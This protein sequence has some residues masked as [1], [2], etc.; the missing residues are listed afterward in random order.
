MREWFKKLQSKYHTFSNMV[1]LNIVL[2][3][4]AIDKL[5]Y[6]FSGY[7]EGH[8]NGSNRR[9]LISR[10]VFANSIVLM[11]AFVFTPKVGLE[12]VS[13][14][15]KLFSVLTVGLSLLYFVWVVVRVLLIR[16]K[17]FIVNPRRLFF[18]CLI[19]TLFTIVA[20]SFV[21]RAFGIIGPDGIAPSILDYLY[22]S[23]VTFSTLGFGDFRPETASRLFAGSQAI[24]GNLHLGI[25]VGATFAAAQKQH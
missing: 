25:I 5:L 8:T 1:G 11:V 6:K 24:L 19:S 17:T 13:W 16:S 18:D 12:M 7:R 21:Y 2:I 20:F 3:F 9:R 22:F 14:A 15:T 10:F 23:A 4:Q